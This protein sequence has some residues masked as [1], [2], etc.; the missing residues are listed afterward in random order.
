MATFAGCIDEIAI[1]DR[2]LEPEEVRTLFEM[3]ERNR[4]L[5]P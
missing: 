2:V 4:P 5:R 1:F 3:G